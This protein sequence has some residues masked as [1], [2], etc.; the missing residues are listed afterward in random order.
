MLKR[1][2]TDAKQG[3][4]SRVLLDVTE[5]MRLSSRSVLTFIFDEISQ[6]N[7]KGKIVFEN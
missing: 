1:E 6:E 5:D 3:A 2:K 4:I 7:L